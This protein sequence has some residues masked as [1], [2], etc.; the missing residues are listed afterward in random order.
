MTTTAA[1]PIA[2]LP[3]GPSSP[4]LV[5]TFQQLLNP[6]TYLA[7]QRAQYGDVFTLKFAGTPPLVVIADPKVIQELFTANPRQFDS[8]EGNRAFLESWVGQN[9]LLVLDG[10]RHARQKRLLMPPFH[11]DRMRAYGEAIQAIAQQVCQDI[12]I[13]QPFIAREMTQRISLQV[14]LRTVFGLEAGDRFT[15]MEQRLGSMVDSMTS[16]VWRSLVVFLK[17]LQQDLGAWSP[18]GKFLRQQRAIDDLIY[19]EIEERR[20]QDSG[21]EDVLSMMM[22]ARDE[23]GQPM[24]DQELRD[25]LMTLLIAGHETTATAIA[26]ALY[27]I[28]RLPEVR[29]QLVAELKGWQGSGAALEAVMKLPYLSAVCD[30]TLRIFPVTLFTFAR[31]PKQTI[32]LGGYRFEPGA[33]LLPSVYLTHRREDLYPQAEQFRP[34]RFL[35]RQF[36]PFEYL[37]FG[38]SNRRC[39]GMA[40][41]QYEMKLALATLLSEGRF[42][43]LDRDPVQAVRRGVTMAPAGALPWYGAPQADVPS[44]DPP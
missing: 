30:E 43:S 12:P 26:W 7:Q 11:G 23:D 20:A 39:I 27:W 44:L 18:W 22:A 2:K 38:G 9:S 15:E 28:H 13:D 1:T 34:E 37:P 6:L 40:F 14:I 10:D 24:T 3:P 41:A 33:M 5:Q 19:R 31:M 17:P 25:E 29:E 8:G 16:S 36:S 32:E 42:E 21:G 4:L 35:E